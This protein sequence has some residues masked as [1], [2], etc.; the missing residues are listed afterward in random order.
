MS[1][2]T[3]TSAGSVSSRFCPDCGAVMDASDNATGTAPRPT[4]R[5]AAPAPR[6][7]PNA[8]PGSRSP[9]RSSGTRTTATLAGDGR[10]HP[11]ELLA[12]RYRIIGLLGKG[13]MGEVYRADDLKLGQAVALKFLP[14]A[15]GQDGERIERFYNEIRVARQVSHPNVCRVYD[16][17]ELQG[18]H[19]LSM[20]FVD[21]EDLA[22]LLRRI[23]RLPGDKAIEIARQLCAGLQAAH[24]KGLLHRDLKPENVMLDGRGKVR[25]T[26]FG[27]AG[28]AESI[29]DDDVR[30]GTP[31]Y[32]SPEQLTGR[33]VSQ[34]SDIYA[35]GLV[36]FEL[37]TGKR[38]FDGRTFRELLRQHQNDLPPSPSQFVTDLD[39]AVE[40]A[41]L[42]CL[43]K[44]PAK[45]PGSALAV[46][47]S[48]PGGDP[49][50]A[51]L[52]AGETPSPEMVAAAGEE[53]RW[54]PVRVWSLL[55]VCLLVFGVLTAVE[56]RH[57]I[58]RLAPFEK[59]PEV[60]VD[61]ARALIAGFG[62]EAA[63]ADTAFGFGYDV[64][65]VVY[66]AERDM[67]RDRWE[68]L[69]REGPPLVHF[70]Y[71]QSPRLMVSTA[72]DGQV[73]ATTP[74]I[75]ISGMSGVRLDTRGRLLEFYAVPPQVEGP[76]SPAAPPDW[77]RLFA[78]AKLDLG[79][80]RPDTPRWN[81]P[82]AYDTRA[83]WEGTDPQWPDTPIRVEAAASHGRPVWFQ[84]VTPWTR[85]ERMQAFKPAW[86][87]SASLWLVTILLLS[88]VFASALLA[89]RNLRT[90][91]GD[92]RG[93]LRLTVFVFA[94]QLAAWA[95]GASHVPDLFAELR[96]ATRGV[97][98]TLLYAGFLG[99][100]YLALEPSVR[101]LWPD[102]LISWTRVLAGRFRD[103]LVGAD[104]LAGVAYALAMRVTFVLVTFGL[105]RL[106]HPTS[107][108]P[109]WT[110]D[111]LLGV[112]NTS[113]LLLGRVFQAIAVGLGMTLLFLGLRVLLRRQWLAA[114]VLCAIM[115]LPD[116]LQSGTSLLL[117]LPIT[118]AI[119]STFVLVLVRHGLLSLVVTALIVW[120]TNLPLT[121]DLAQWYALPSK[122]VAL[123]F[124][125]L[126]AYATRAALSRAH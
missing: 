117:A 16:V 34:R 49:L 35:L 52:A 38:A 115:S 67:S 25:I 50:A 68:R 91:R 83:A 92:R 30:S 45:R 70:W 90:G 65:H 105:D 7:T 74:P 86:Q 78:E 27:L 26:D 4:P 121:M 88:A 73:Y 28:L 19:Y 47:A 75:N 122:V 15:F 98:L 94:G 21:G 46:A 12:E 10:F 41:I 95:L 97:G 5:D 118:M 23:G 1:C 108:P 2:P 84:I 44:D 9:R 72:E 54:R 64:D 20:E 36:L 87:Q 106:G 59:P 11:G 6:S 58:L 8:D 114:V 24:D 48:L 104:V 120:L 109:S 96:L 66:A 126:C 61:R 55:A 112:V 14:L 18:D 33:Q 40:R 56:S 79:A 32:M 53:N 103:P 110:L 17:G 119:F 101:R 29:A 57:S 69:A 125:G 37:F 80:L 22:S 51:A 71:R 85:P 76:V 82:F 89:R 60:L 99:L 102:A 100:L 63:P 123:V 124:A 111:A 77:T 39:P 3:C 62:H 81:P 116:A 113:A 43:E 31:A 42:R 93:A 107:F 13:G